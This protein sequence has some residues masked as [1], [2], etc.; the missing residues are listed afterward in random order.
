MYPRGLAPTYHSTASS[1][2]PSPLSQSFQQAF[3]TSREIPTSPN[4]GQR[5]S[6]QTQ[7]ESSNS[8]AHV[9]AAST[10]LI[11]R[12]DFDIPNSFPQNN[13]ITPSLFTE[14]LAL[15]QGHSLIQAVAFPTSL[16]SFC[17]GWAGVSMGFDSSNFLTDFNNLSP[18]VDPGAGLHSSSQC[19]ETQ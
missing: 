15:Q 5:P 2:T 16:P 1:I 12:S 6:A 4:I 3:E 19:Q 18:L 17:H 8:Q 11:Y 14:P 13:A 9:F 10:T 7:V